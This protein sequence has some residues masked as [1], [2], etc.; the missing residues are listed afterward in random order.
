MALI[1]DFV[2]VVE[3]ILVRDRH[4]GLEMTYAME[5]LPPKSPIFSLPQG[6][7][8]RKIINFGVLVW[9]EL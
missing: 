5:I 6:G 2:V 7:T 3:I 1:I 9:Y 8:R 4:N